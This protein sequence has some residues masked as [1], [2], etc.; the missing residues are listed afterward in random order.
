MPRYLFNVRDRD[1]LLLDDPRGCQPPN[2]EAVKRDAVQ[3]ARLILCAAALCGTAAGLQV[4]IE[5]VD[6]AG[7]TVLIMP[8]G[9]ATGSESQT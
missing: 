4:Q 9:H 6:E 7:D 5:V 1:D 3:A 8:V 2:L